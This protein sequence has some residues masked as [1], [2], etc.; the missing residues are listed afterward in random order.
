MTWTWS[1]KKSYCYCFSSSDPESL[2]S[3]G[4][5]ALTNPLAAYLELRWGTPS[6]VTQPSAQTRERELRTVRRETC[7]RVLARPLTRPVALDKSLP[8]KGPFGHR[9][10]PQWSQR[11]LPPLPRFCACLPGFMWRKNK[12]AVNIQHK[13]MVIKH[14]RLPRLV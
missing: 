11:S 12:S 3:F 8:C 9:K 7:F 4:I 10:E 6:P 5:N 13:S 2:N 1:R 14:I